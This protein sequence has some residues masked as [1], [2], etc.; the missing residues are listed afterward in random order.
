MA[1]LGGKKFWRCTVCGD[2]HF[3]VLPPETCPTCQHVN[4]YV[5]T[6]IFEAKA[7]MRL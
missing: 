7:V 2:I 3:G 5:E 4:V 1:N 6:D